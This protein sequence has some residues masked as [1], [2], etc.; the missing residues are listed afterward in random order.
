MSK[1]KSKDTAPERAVRSALHR[2]GLRFRKHPKDLPGKPDVVFTRK[3][4]AVFVDGDFWHGFGFEARAA[5]LTPFWR[6]KI[7][8]NMTRDREDERRLRESGWR[9]VRLWE[10]EVRRDLEGCVERVVS[11]LAEAAPRGP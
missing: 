10:H 9:V 4:V 2:R 5:R 1:V 3:K 6:A 7:E 11:A 8:R